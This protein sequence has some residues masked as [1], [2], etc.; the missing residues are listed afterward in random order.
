MWWSLARPVGAKRSWPK[1]KVCSRILFWERG[2]R[3]AKGNDLTVKTG[4]KLAQITL[5]FPCYVD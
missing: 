4:P 1:G 2:R 3:V 5:I